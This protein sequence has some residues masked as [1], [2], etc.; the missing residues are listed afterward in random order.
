MNLVDRFSW[1]STK[2]FTFVLS[3]CPTKVG[4]SSSPKS[5]QTYFCHTIQNSEKR[6]IYIREP[7]NKHT[8]NYFKVAT[9]CSNIRKSVSITVSLKIQTLKLI[10]RRMIF[11]LHSS[12]T[13]VAQEHIGKIFNDNRTCWRHYYWKMLFFCCLFIVPPTKLK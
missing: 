2:F 6:N 11:F 8:P 13:D 3:Q 7:G 9:L 12:T 5:I 10:D 4:L 1:F